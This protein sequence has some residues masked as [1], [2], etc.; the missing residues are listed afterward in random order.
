MILSNVE[1]CSFTNLADGHISMSASEWQQFQRMTNAPYRPRT[2]REFNAMC[3]MAVARHDAEFRIGV[4]DLGLC[5]AVAVQVMK[6]GP[7]GEVNFPI[8]PAQD[9]YMKKH[10]TFPTG[11]ELA[12]FLATSAGG[13]ERPHLELVR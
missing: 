3:D 1:V 12:Q 9:A 2:I 10:G 7:N 5:R 4:D 11:E 6:F 13:I 8:T